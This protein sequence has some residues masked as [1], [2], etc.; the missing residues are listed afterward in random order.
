MAKSSGRFK[1]TPGS[2]NFCSRNTSGMH[3]PGRTGNTN[4]PAINLPAKANKAANKA[5]GGG[6]APCMKTA[7]RAQIDRF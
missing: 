7:C 5:R 1:I 4:L 2:M 3:T 6:E